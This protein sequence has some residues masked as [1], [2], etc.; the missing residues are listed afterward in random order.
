[1]G[2][3]QVKWFLG[4]NLTDE[5]GGGRSHEGMSSHQFNAHLKKSHGG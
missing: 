3:L 5:I 2:I 4:R 1:M